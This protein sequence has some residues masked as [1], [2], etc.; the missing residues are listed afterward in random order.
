MTLLKDCQAV[1]NTLSR[2][3]LHHIFRWLLYWNSDNVFAKDSGVLWKSS[4]KASKNTFK[5]EKNRSPHTVEA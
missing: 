5:V 1:L 2:H 4:W 3:Y